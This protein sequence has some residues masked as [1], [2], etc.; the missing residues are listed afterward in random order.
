MHRLRLIADDLTGALDAAAQFT[1]RIGPLPVFWPGRIPACLPPS[2]AIDTGTREEGEAVAALATAR[3]ASALAPAPGTVSYFKLDSLLRGHPSRALAAILH[4]LSP[5]HC[6]IAPAFPFQRRRTRDGR[7]YAAGPNGW[8]PTGEHLPAAL[9]AHGITVSLARPGDPVPEGVSVW[10]AETEA[11][12]ARIAAAG[13]ALAEPV[14]WCGSAGLAGALATPPATPPAAPPTA[15]LARPLLGIFGSDHPVTTAQLRAA[16]PH[17]VRLPETSAGEAAAAVDARLA[18]TGIALVSFSLPPD[19]SRAAAGERIARA[20]ATLLTRL[21]RPA[22]LLVSG[23]ETVRAVCAALD[24]THLEVRGQLMPGVP[25]S[26]LRGGR[27]DLIPLIS[28]S[29]AFGGESLL[30]EIT[31]PP[32]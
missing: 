14:L 19:L 13:R 3:L 15:P 1:A 30:A 28:K 21:A 17:H 10:D 29:G 12:I 18:A 31:A 24:A 2:A 22:A 16:F 6:I 9:A 25:H 27:W 7:Q 4:A 8:T 5:R 23:G 26:L 11:D 32:E 20:A